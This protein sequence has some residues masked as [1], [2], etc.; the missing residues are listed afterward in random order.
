MPSPDECIMAKAANGEV[1]MTKARET[2]RMFREEVDDLIAGGMGKAEAEEKV[3]QSMVETAERGVARKRT[4]AMVSVIIQERIRK[5]QV[6]AIANKVDVHRVMNSVLSMDRM[7]LAKG[8]P[9]LEAR[10]HDV[11][12]S[13]YRR[14]TDHLDKFRTKALGFRQDHTD[15]PDV[16]RE[17]FGQDSGNKAAK[18]IA[19]SLKD[20]MEYARLRFNAAGGDIANRKDWGLWQQ[21]DASKMAGGTGRE[22]IDFLLQEDMLDLDSIFA[23]NGRRMTTSQ[24]KDS[25]GI[26][27]KDIL[28]GGMFSRNGPTISN[29]YGSAVNRRANE[30]VLVFK[31]A[32]AW[33]KYHAKYGRGNI[34]DH[35]NG[36]LDTLAKDISVLEILGPYPEATI[37]FM[38]ELVA[39][40]KN[41]GAVQ[42]TGKAAR[43][44]Q[45]AAN[46]G[47]D[48]LLNEYHILSGANS[49]PADNGGW[50]TAMAAN[51]SFQTIISLGNAFL[52]ALGG[53]AATTFVTAQMNGL[54]TSRIMAR[55]L[56]LF[57]GASDVDRRMANRAGFVVTSWSNLNI[58]SSRLMG[59]TTGPQI[60]ER[61]SDTALRVTGLTQSTEAYRIAVG[62]EMLA[63]ITEHAGRSF[64]DLDGPMRNSF[65]RHGIDADD[66]DIIRTS[67][68]FVD[69]ETKADFIVPDNV[70]RGEFNTKNFEVANKLHQQI[71]NET[72]FAVVTQNSRTQNLLT[73]GS[74]PGTWIGEVRRSAGLFKGWPIAVLGQHLQRAAAQKGKWGTAKYM[75]KFGISLTLAGALGEQL[76]GITSGRDPEAM[77]TGE[78]WLRAFLRGG[79]SGIIGDALLQDAGFGRGVIDSLVGPV[80]GQLEDAFKLTG[81]T[82]VDLI[83]EDSLE[84]VTDPF[85]KRLAAA[86]QHNAPGKTGWYFKLA[87]QRMW[88]DQVRDA[89]DP[90]AADAFYNM[91][92]RAEQ[93][94]GQ[95]YWWKPGQ[96]APDRGPQL[97]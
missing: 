30:R 43:Q 67:E 69:P 2:R 32:D 57:V 46:A 49:I 88:W 28:S 39:E 12:A 97:P 33:M 15:L 14:V 74:R 54:S 58:T 96:T 79:A 89:I 59:E 10:I 5:L 16:V 75:T 52:M 7:E 76:Y 48:V 20:A 29:G 1:D 66:W 42:G 51:R 71:F 47:N 17:L 82:A 11:K 13:I 70:S 87:L 95:S 93:E 81:G 90:D 68:R 83:K 41:A 25:L 26:A 18:E 31:N 56:K 23:D 19:G 24:L 63:N 77:D 37:K 4:M 6:D 85:R 22:W 44:L 53:D 65:I 40:A 45:A 62:M 21:H 9:N 80:G 35:I 84:D 61:A 50:S 91:E 38:N 27:Y 55:Y 86:I 64:D 78:F 8:V 34:F 94:H 36:S 72:Q 73:G 3:A 60:M 92:V